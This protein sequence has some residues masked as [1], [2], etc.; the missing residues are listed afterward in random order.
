[1]R[2]MVIVKASESTEA[3]RLPSPELLDAMN[4]FNEELSLGGA[5]WRAACARG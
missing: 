5:L 1:M 4:V 2:F 3:G